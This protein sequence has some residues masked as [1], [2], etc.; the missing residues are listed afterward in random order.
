VTPA[1]VQKLSAEWRRRK[2]KGAF[3]VWDPSRL[4][5]LMK[6]REHLARSWSGAKE[7]R[8][9]QKIILPAWQWLQ[10]AE[11]VGL[12]WSHDPLW[13]LEI[14]TYQVPT[15]VGAFHQNFT[16]NYRL[17]IAPRAG[18][19]RQIRTD[20]QFHYASTIAYPRALHPFEDVCKAVETLGKA[21][22]RHVDLLRDE[23]VVRVPQ[24]ER[25]GDAESRHE[26]VDALAYCVL[27][28]QWGFPMRGLHSIRGGRLVIGGRYQAWEEPALPEIEPLLDEM[29]RA[30]PHGVVDSSVAK[31]RALVV[32]RVHEWWRLLW[33]VVSF[34]IDAEPESP[35]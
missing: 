8:C 18:A 12:N 23:L 16:W 9:L 20:P 2:Q 14:Q 15:P 32:K 28:N 26:I 25:I 3:C 5:A 10:E 33:Q 13:P 17:R 29:V 7:A 4:N 22:R 6:G 24:L 19:L 11:A 27:E 30:V 21:V 31:A 35:A 1:I 34:G